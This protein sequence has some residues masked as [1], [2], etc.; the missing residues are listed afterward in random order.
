M[1]F[2]QLLVALA[3]GAFAISHL[4]PAFLGS[5]GLACEQVVWSALF[6]R[7][8][9]EAYVAA[10]ALT[11]TSFVVLAILSFT[12]LG[13]RTGLRIL[14]VVMLAHVL[15]WFALVAFWFVTGAEKEFHIQIGYYLWAM[16]YGFLVWV[17][18]EKRGE[19]NQPPGRRPAADRL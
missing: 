15:S 6:K 16:A 10:F 13:H 1:R 4:L 18:Y 3:L 14:S 8:L 12:R 11:N 2:S 9:Q 19:P 5:S 7:P 17:F